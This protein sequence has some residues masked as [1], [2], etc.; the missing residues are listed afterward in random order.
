MEREDVGE[1]KENLMSESV[2]KSE[3]WTHGVTSEGP[4]EGYRVEKKTMKLDF[5]PR[6][7]LT[8]YDTVRDSTW[9]GP[10]IGVVE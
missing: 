8:T 6:F 5:S 1:E 7:L 2:S 3:P 4:T 9:E 10:Q